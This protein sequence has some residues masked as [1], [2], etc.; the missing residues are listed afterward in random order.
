MDLK[1]RYATASSGELSAK[2][3]LSMLRRDVSEKQH[4]ALDLI[5][6]M[7]VSQNRL[8]EIS[9]R[10]NPIGSTKYIDLLM[11]SEKQDRKPGWRDRVRALEELQQ[12][13][14]IMMDVLEDC[15][16]PCGAACKAASPALQRAASKYSKGGS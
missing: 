2:Q 10:P 14:Q 1:K 13:A 8:S 12:K 7:R 11:Q 4:S 16:D 5:E 3:V 15:N 9:L 6:Q